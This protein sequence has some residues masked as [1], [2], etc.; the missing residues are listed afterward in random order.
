MY[1]AKKRSVTEMYVDL[2]RASIEPTKP[3]H[4]MRVANVW[5]QSREMF[6][7]LIERGLLEKKEV[8]IR[9]KR[10]RFLY[11]TTEKGLE[12]I[13]LFDKVKEILQP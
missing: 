6:P 5:S 2:L 9:D 1:A 10:T 3:H 11:Q 8:L 13:L 4:V 7:H 12:L